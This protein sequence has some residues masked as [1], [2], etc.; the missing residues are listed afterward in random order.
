MLI[1]EHEDL[2]RDWPGETLPLVGALQA[3]REG[4]KVWLR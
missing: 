3:V 2:S 1:D 4:G